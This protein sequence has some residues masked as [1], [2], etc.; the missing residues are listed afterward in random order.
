LEDAADRPH[1]SA[2]ATALVEQNMHLRETIGLALGEIDRLVEGL[3][4]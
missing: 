4:R 3:E 1:A 2:P